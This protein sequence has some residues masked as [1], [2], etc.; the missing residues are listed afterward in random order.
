VARQAS[1]AQGGG[2]E[3]P[4]GLLGAVKTGLDGQRHGMTTLIRIAPPTE[5]TSSETAI[6]TDVNVG[7]G[8]K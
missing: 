3:R 7:E 5:S 2:R 6:K 4:D 1:T 8:R